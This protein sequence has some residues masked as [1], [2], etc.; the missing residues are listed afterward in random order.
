M[1]SVFLALTLLIIISPSLFSQEQK[2]P[3]VWEPLKYFVGA[4]KGTGTGESGEATVERTY[5]FILNGKFL[6]AQNTS[7]YKPQEKNP[8]GE[9]HQHWDLFSYDRTRKKFILRQFHQEGFINQYV[10][11]S[12]S[13]DKKVLMFTSEAIE[14][15]SAGW[16]ARE[17]YEIINE[18][19]FVESFLL[20][21]P[22]KEFS[23]YSKNTL[24]RVKQP[25]E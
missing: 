5:D 14:N 19:E 23:L 9:H 2:K 1:K 8:K 17:I 3:D 24:M 16:R 11:D 4:W 7:D 15:I 20:S 10:L 25:V 21:E 12:I 22:G 18:N 6:H 13:S